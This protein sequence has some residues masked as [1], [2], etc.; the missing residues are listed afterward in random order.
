MADRRPNIK[1]TQVFYHATGTTGLADSNFAKSI[2][3]N[4]VVNGTAVLVEEVGS[5][6][7]RFSFTPLSAGFWQVSVAHS[8]TLNTR[9]V[10]DYFVEAK[11]H[12]SRLADE[13]RALSIKIGGLLRG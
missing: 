9:Y 4:G 13:V 2:F 12:T 3:L 6:F 10:G 5:G 11:D 1:I 7:Y 8:T